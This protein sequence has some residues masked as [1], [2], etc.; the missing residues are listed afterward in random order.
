MTKELIGALAIGL[1]G[2]IALSVW[3]RNRRLR[4]N[5][6]DLLEAPKNFD[7]AEG[8]KVFYV[9]TVFAKAPLDRVWAYGLGPRGKAY[10]TFTATGFGIVRNGE[11]GF[12]IPFSGVSALDRISATIDKAV[13]KGGLTA[14]TWKLGSTELQTVLRIVDPK[15]RE[16]LETRLRSVIGATIG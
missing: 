15:I 1:V 5:Q 3:L 10:I 11:T 9:S 13:E 2:L 6:E 7:A 12:E 14:I 8:L 16:E 4:K